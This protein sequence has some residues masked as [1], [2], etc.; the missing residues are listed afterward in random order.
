MIPRQFCGFCAIFD[1]GM[2]TLRPKLLLF[3]TLAVCAIGWKIHNDYAHP[4]ATMALQGDPLPICPP[5]C[6]DPP[7]PPPPCFACHT[8]TYP[9]GFTGLRNRA[10]IHRKSHL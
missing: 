2:N 9:N 8:D 1:N 3:A 10:P 5:F 7:P 4:G 6:D